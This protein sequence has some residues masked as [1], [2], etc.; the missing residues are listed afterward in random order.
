[1]ARQWGKVNAGTEYGRPSKRRID[2]DA[3]GIRPLIRVGRRL[4]R[5]G[6]RLTFGP[7]LERIDRLRQHRSR[8]I[9]SGVTPISGGCNGLREHHR[10]DSKEQKKRPPAFFIRFHRSLIRTAIT[11]ILPK[12]LTSQKARPSF[13]RCLVQENQG[14]FCASRPTMTCRVFRSSFLQ[15]PLSRPLKTS[16]S[17]GL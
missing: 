6:R 4:R 11:A 9:C 10:A 2:S 7:W 14:P 15:Y 3:P 16:K 5:R 12:G 8:G 13:A 1:M 17:T